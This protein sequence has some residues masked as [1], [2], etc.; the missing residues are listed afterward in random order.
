MASYGPR[1]IVFFMMPPESDIFPCNSAMPKLSKLAEKSL[2]EIK[3][4]CPS[5][6]NLRY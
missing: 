1:R 6:V 4:L 5:A 3:I 2:T